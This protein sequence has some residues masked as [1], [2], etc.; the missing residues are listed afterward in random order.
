MEHNSI[1]HTRKL[2]TKRHCGEGDKSERLRA[3][4][5]DLYHG[6]ALSFATHPW[7]RSHH[8]VMM[9]VGRPKTSSDVKGPSERPLPHRLRETSIH[10][11][12]AGCKSLEHGMRHGG[13]P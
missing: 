13:P 7:V 12:T 4:Q 5:A 9:T 8:T 1:E 10:L 2:G 6:A 11:P 3:G